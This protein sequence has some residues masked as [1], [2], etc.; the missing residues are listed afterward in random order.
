MFNT[1]AQPNSVDGWTFCGNLFS[2]GL[3]NYSEADSFHPSGVNALL[4]DGSVNFIKSSIAQNIW[5]A[6]GTKSN[7][8]VISADQY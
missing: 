2:S 4:A 8:E 6:L 1:V 3:V 5:W 7:D